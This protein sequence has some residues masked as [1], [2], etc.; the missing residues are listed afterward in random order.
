LT[1]DKCHRPVSLGWIAGVRAKA[2]A[3]VESRGCTDLVAG[4]LR[5]AEA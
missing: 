1:H 3:L 4:L 5:Q 2:T